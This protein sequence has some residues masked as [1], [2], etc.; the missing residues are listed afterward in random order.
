MNN[1]IPQ[2]PFNTAPSGVKPLVYGSQLGALV[3]G[4]LGIEQT[5]QDAQEENQPL[6]KALG[7]GA[8]NV[9]GGATLGTLTGLGG[10]V[11]LNRA[12]GIN[13][14]QAL[15][16]ANKYTFGQPAPV[17]KTL[18]EKIHTPEIAAGVLGAEAGLAAYDLN[19]LHNLHNTLGEIQ[20]A[21]SFSYMSTVANFASLVPIG[22]GLGAVKGMLDQPNG[23]LLNPETGVIENRTYTPFERL[24]NI[25]IN[26]GVGAGLGLGANKLGLNNPRQLGRYMGKTSNYLEDKTK[27]IR[28]Y[29]PEVEVRMKQ[30][31]PLPTEIV[32]TLNKVSKRNNN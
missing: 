2:I 16:Y 25:G 7:N 11:L 15:D 31:E 21:M 29:L 32:D 24:T 22:A 14:R 19:E 3:G 23:Q 9:A 30:Q 20:T 18:L 5:I 26:A 13:N 4:G 6:P 1:L 28:E 17:Q 12:R 8:L 27:K 10:G